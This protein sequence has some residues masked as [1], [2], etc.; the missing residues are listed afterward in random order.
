MPSDGLDLIAVAKVILA[1]RVIIALAFGC[2]GM[3][4]CTIVVTPLLR[5]AFKSVP[6]RWKLKLA[7][8]PDLEH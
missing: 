2:P 5:L 3:M 4:F 8:G 1:G 7:G 6:R